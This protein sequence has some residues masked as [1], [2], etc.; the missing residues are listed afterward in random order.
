MILKRFA[1]GV[2]LPHPCFCFDAQFAI[3]PHIDRLDTAEELFEFFPRRN[4]VDVLHHGSAIG[5]GQNYAN[6]DLA[7]D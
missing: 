5:K 1:Y 6:L 7:P 4:H 2:E 3:D